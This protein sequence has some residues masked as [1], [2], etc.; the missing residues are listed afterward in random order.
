MYKK[1]VTALFLTLAVLF[2]QF[3]T[4]IYLPGANGKVVHLRLD[5][6][7]KYLWGESAQGLR[8]LKFMFG[9]KWVRVPYT[10]IAISW[11]E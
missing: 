11:E 2:V 1:L 5:K 3:R 7:N 6:H 8:Y 4:P 10:N 9:G